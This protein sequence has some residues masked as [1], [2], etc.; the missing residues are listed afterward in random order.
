MRRWREEETRSVSIFALHLR[1]QKD[2]RKTVFFVFAE[3][4]CTLATVAG[5]RNAKRFDF[6]TILQNKIRNSDA[7]GLRFLF[8]CDILY[9]PDVN[10]G[11]Y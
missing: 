3:E 8:F 4:I 1:Q 7:K 5:R 11:E 9:M 6:Y 2:S 10:K